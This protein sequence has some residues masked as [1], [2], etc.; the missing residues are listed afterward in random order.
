METQKWIDEYFSWLKKRYSV[1][2]LEDSDEIITPFENT[3]GD[4]IVLYVSKLKN[5]N[6]ELTDDGE[7]IDNLE[8]FDFEFTP[9]RTNII[10]GIANS[11][12]VEVTEEKELRITGPQKRFPEM[13]Q[14]LIQAI[15]R[16][17]DMIMLQK[18]NLTSIF[19]EDVINFFDKNNFG[20]LPKYNVQGSTG[21]SYSISYAIGK[22]N[23]KPWR[24]IQVVN[25]ISFQKVATETI[26]YNDISNNN[27]YN[28]SISYNII[29]NQEEK[30]PSSKSSKIASQYGLNLISW[31]DKNKI[32]ELK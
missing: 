32:F 21:N 13:K 16:V 8:L 2:S 23:F 12:K 29:F 6:I 19:F 17:D 9:I 4:N 25:N 24:F 11:L 7:T 30:S 15:L 26:I 18:Q 20:G 1:Q 5:G 31:E 10:K 27:Y 22:Q 28:N 3:I 14:N